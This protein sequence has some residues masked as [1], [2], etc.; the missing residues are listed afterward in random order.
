[1]CARTRIPI[2]SRSVV[3]SPA[4]AFFPF[5]SILPW[6]PLLTSPPPPNGAMAQHCNLWEH[7]HKVIA[8]CVWSW[9]A[10]RYLHHRSI[11]FS[12]RRHLKLVIT[13]PRIQLPRDNDPLS[14]S[15]ASSCR[16][17]HP[18]LLLFVLSPHT[19]YASESRCLKAPLAS[20]RGKILLVT[21]PWYPL[22]LFWMLSACPLKW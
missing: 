9:T 2:P 21:L 11:Q 15:T 3:F 16:Q 1:M 13:P 6:L 4:P 12:S 20:I 19:L 8:T 18:A 7:H 5:A 22:H 14:T 10:T 17:H